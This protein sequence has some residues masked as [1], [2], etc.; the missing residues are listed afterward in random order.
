MQEG[1]L[2]AERFRIERCAGVGAM[3]AVFRAR[4]LVTSEWVAVKTFRLDGPLPSSLRFSREAEALA[5][6]HDP[7]IVRYIQHGLR[8][9][10]RPF[11]VMEWIEGPT[12]AE[13]LSVRGLSA[14]ETLRL[15][16]RLARALGALH[17][18]GI[19]H[20]DLKPSNVM[21]PGGDV[22]AAR[23]VDFGVARIV[24][25]AVEI[26][27]QG[28]QLGTPRYMAPEQ[29][30]DPHRVDGRADVFALGCILFECLT[31]TPA[32]GG[33]DTVA[34]LAQILFQP[35]PEPSSLAPELP[36][37]VDRWLGRLL[38]RRPE[39]R[40]EAAAIAAQIDALLAPPTGAELTALPRA[41]ARRS[42]R[43]PASAVRARGL[44]LGEDTVE[45]DVPVLRPS[46]EFRRAGSRD[47]DAALPA[48]AGVLIGRQA[49]LSALLAELATGAPIVIRGGPGVGKTRLA[50]ELVERAQT[51]AVVPS[52]ALLFA[53]LSSA[54][55]TYDAARL[56]ADRAGLGVEATDQPEARIGHLLAKLGS[57]ILVLDKVEHLGAE[58]AALMSLWASSAPHLQLIAT[59]RVRLQL[60]CAF[61]L[62]PLAT[63]ERARLRSHSAPPDMTAA[64]DPLAALSPAAR[65]VLERARAAVP[66][67]AAGDAFTPQVSDAL[68]RI[69]S[70]LDG[71]PLAI[72][73]AAAR[74][75]VLGLTG[76]LTRLASQLELLSG[77]DRDSGVATMR[78][79]LAWSWQLLGE[80]ERWVF[81]QCALFRGGFT[82]PA[83]QAL[84][85]L[86]PSSPPLVDLLRSLRE[87]SLLVSSVQGGDGLQVRLSMF[88]AVR[89]YALEQLATNTHVHPGL[90]G[91]PARHARYHAALAER[92]GREARSGTGA[93]ARAQLDH[94]HEN[95]VTAAEHALAQQPP[96][97]H[98]ALQVLLALEPVLLARGPGSELAAVLERA[99]TAAE[100]QAESASVLHLARARQLRARLLVPAG[101]LEHAKAELARVLDTA[102]RHADRALQ[103]SARLDLGVAHHFARDLDRA[104]AC[105]ERALE[106]L[107]DGD[108]AAAEARCQ[109]NLA[110]IHH[111]RGELLLAAPGYRRAIA[112]LEESG[113]PR[114]LAN[115]CG[116]LA[117]CEHELGRPRS[118]RVLYERACGLLEPLGDARLLGIVLGNLG[119]LALAEHDPARA[120]ALHERACALLEGSGDR[121]SEGLALGRRAA[122][123]SCLG[124]LDEAERHM[125]A[126]ERLLRRDAIGRAV[127]ELLRAL[128]DLERARQALEVDAAALA[129]AELASAERRIAQARQALHHGKPLHDQCDD[130][131][132][133]LQVIEA[134]L[135]QVRA[136]LA[137]PGSRERGSA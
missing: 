137:R 63:A 10:G 95:L 22:A 101:E 125:A 58:I 103:A 6:L 112:L 20:R 44:Q 60:P 4:D 42:V 85:E 92:L 21:L 110:A 2:V 134:R 122:A 39:L 96:E 136:E 12:L 8:E 49:E 91:A 37:A 130:L 107:A 105:Y 77:S 93:N 38:A 16:Q 19:V 36:E 3:G 90:A 124:R 50:L 48:P 1:D 135:Q 87:Q 119:T 26:T 55:T 121:R 111:D 43:A 34:V 117:L 7:G 72:E 73:L 81:M 79:A 45:R 71:I 74:V 104:R 76:V 14:C 114:L 80:P 40:P 100:A 53:D 24:G 99:I 108:D 35:A 66:E 52:D 133:Y 18:R 11:L 25:S 86:A 129:D 59:S 84:V 17:A 57:V 33:D 9:D 64:G 128:L 29:I 28:A 94:E 32:F 67:L 61:E 123:L 89:E 82:L 102:D 51:T 54:R 113:E 115:F 68:E 31:G 132:L 62:L 88:A 78:G 126:G 131:R 97:P 5:E 127:I 15:G 41:P 47:L 56:V 23:I 13:Q 70:A 30:R 27:A 98:P 69:A 65:L 116:N 120:L 46:A 106:L 83:A 109:G 75:S 118:A